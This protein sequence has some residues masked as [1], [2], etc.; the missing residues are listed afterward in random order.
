M[1]VSVKT[2]NTF[3]LNA[4]REETSF[5]L[6]VEGFVFRG[7]AAGISFFLAPFAGFA[8]AERACT[9]VRGEAIGFAVERDAGSRRDLVE[10]AAMRLRYH[11]ASGAEI[12]HP[13]V[14]NGKNGH[15]RSVQRAL[16]GPAPKQ[17]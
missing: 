17:S 14:L 10:E 5:V 1:I 12:A 7:E 13:I 2:L 9:W 6:P 8:A 4:S 16:S 3:P 15:R 11:P